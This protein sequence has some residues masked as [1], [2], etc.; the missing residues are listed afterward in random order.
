MHVMACVYCGGA[1][2]GDQAGSLNRFSTQR[3]EKHFKD[4][5]QDPKSAPWMYVRYFFIFSTVIVCW[6]LTLATDS[7]AT[8]ILLALPMGFACALVCYDGTAGTAVH[9]VR[10]RLLPGLLFP[11]A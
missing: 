8:Q 2:H 9:A 7:L 3:V 1:F 6:A 4:T 10:Q 5:K 11:P